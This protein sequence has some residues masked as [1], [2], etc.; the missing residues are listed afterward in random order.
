MVVPCHNF[1]SY[2]KRKQDAYTDGTLTFMHKELIMLATNKFNLLKQEGTW[3]AKSPDK[4]KIAAM[5]AELTALKGQ[6]QLAPNLKKAAGAKGPRMMTRKEARSKVEEITRK[7]RTRRTML[8]RK[9]RRKMRTGRRHL[10]RNEKLTRRRSMGVPGVGVST[11][12]RGE[13]T[14]NQTADLTKTAPTNRTAAVTKL[15]PKP[16]WQPSSTPSGK[17]SLPT[18]PATWP[19]NDWPDPHGNHGQCS[20]KFSWRRQT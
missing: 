4:D 15:R 1:R 16:P 18:W 17:P 14:R 12:W 20:G 10:P 19:M 11:I 13:T 2:I 9:S 3:G 8:T 7:R 5:Q 6:F